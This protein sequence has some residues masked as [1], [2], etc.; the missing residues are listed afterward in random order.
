VSKI[1]SREKINSKKFLFMI[2]EKKKPSAKS[3]TVWG[4]ESEREI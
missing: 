4:K 2:L 3:K 1:E